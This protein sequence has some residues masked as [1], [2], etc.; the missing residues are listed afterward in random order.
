MIA[1]LRLTL[2]SLFFPLI[3]TNSFCFLGQRTHSDFP[4]KFI[5]SLLLLSLTQIPVNLVLG[6][7]PTDII[8]GIG[9]QY[10]IS[11][12]PGENF[13]VG[14][15]E[16]LAYTNEEV[17]GNL[18]IRGEKLG[19][20]DIILTSGAGET[21]RFH[22]YVNSKNHLLKI[23]RIQQLIRGLG[24]SSRPQGPFLFVSGTLKTASSYRG[25]H[26]LLKI[27]KDL[28][29][30]RVSISSG[31]KQKLIAGIYEIYGR[32]G[33]WG[34]SCF[35]A[36]II[37]LC[38]FPFAISAQNK[39]ILKRLYFAQTEIKASS[40][41]TKNFLAE[42][43]IFQADVHHFSTQSL[44][45]NRLQGGL[46][47]LLEQGASSL[48]NANIVHFEEGEA[49]IEVLAQPKLLLRI[50]KRASIS[51]GGEVAFS[52]NQLS[53]NSGIVQ[54]QDWK[55]AGFRFSLTLKE[56]SSGQLEALYLTEFARPGS[57]SLNGSRQKGS[58]FIQDDQILKV[59]DLTL[60]KQQLDTSAL[61]WF[62]KIPLI[63]GLFSS[64]SSG[65]GLQR[66]FA[67]LKLTIPPSSPH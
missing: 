57:S 49:R 13:S 12:L 64:R 8:L 1:I 61:P 29:I 3:F 15:K 46:G 42:L 45:L 53:A 7:S 63:G 6:A 17:K 48:W 36:D 26:Q 44:G 50:G 24:L 34:M 38:R 4:V 59:F 35:F 66:V 52:Q 55:F 56:N 27:E 67:L 65:H 2:T 11:L 40:R 28:M 19:F 39:K 10:Q 14:N 60:K 33:R 58:F 18:L 21:R 51:L 54:T 9:E 32:D 62:Q 22:I 25:Y 43:R 20:S 30:S 47:N 16:I 5:K 41:S 37:P 23:K 31:L